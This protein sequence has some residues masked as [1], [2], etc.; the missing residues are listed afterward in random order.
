MNYDET[1]HY[2]YNALPAFHKIGVAAYKEGLDN[3]LALD[4]RFNHPHRA[5]Q[6]I[7]IAGTNGKGSISHTLAAIFQS[8][9]YKTGL[10]TSP[11]LVDFRERI[12]VNGE[13]IDKEYVVD[14]V[15]RNKEF[16]E[17]LQ[18]SFFEL[19]MMMAFCYF[20]S[21]KVDIALIEVGLGGRLDSTNVITP[22]LAIIS[23]ISFDHTQFLGDTLEKIAG[24]KAGIIKPHI[25]VVIGEAGT[26]EVRAVFQKK[27]DQ[28][29]APIFF[30]EEEQPL[31]SAT[32]S[33][34]GWVYTTKEY[35]QLEG[36]LG[37]LA[38]KKNT[39]TVLSAL[40][41]LK[42]KGFKLPDAAIYKGFR[43]VTSLTGL[44][45][46]WQIVRNHP[47][48][49]C[50]TGHNSGGIRY[51]ADQLQQETYRTLRI[52]IGM[53]NDKDITAVLKLLPTEAIYYFTKAAIPRAL[54]EQLLHKQ[55][56]PFGLHGHDFPSVKEAV[57]TALHDCNPDDLLF[58][59]GSNFI[60][61]EALPLF[62]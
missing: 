8:A 44:M 24:E 41:L 51:V 4:T 13:M 62:Q 47:K 60:I 9:G 48:V 27:A 54:D 33:S 30:A 22:E 49:I 16:F 3:T 21:Q 26:P 37:G 5:Y 58:I 39:V 32:K 6:T 31:L 55:A 23:N 40:R 34:T 1:L 46:R 38:Q 28:E 29:K 43:K 56:A 12:R 42:E 61:A 45:G 53:V 20:E 19:T 7:H 50:D 59:G 11:H 10:Y 18:P 17:Q 57:E 14:Y 52:V 2:L 35:Q 36:E 15:A 25:P